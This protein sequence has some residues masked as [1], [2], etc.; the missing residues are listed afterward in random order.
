[1]RRSTLDFCLGGQRSPLGPVCSIK[2]PLL[3]RSKGNYGGRLPEDC[4]RDLALLFFFFTLVTGPRRSLSLKLSDTR[5]YEPQMRARLGTT[6]DLASL[7]LAGS[8][9]GSTSPHTKTKL[10]GFRLFDFLRILVYLVIY[11]SG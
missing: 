5:V 4:P 10:M 1:M 11:D 8:M 7:L 2:F 6:R 3:S 9:E